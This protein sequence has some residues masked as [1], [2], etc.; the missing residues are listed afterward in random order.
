[1]D[2]SIKIL[3]DT[4]NIEIKRLGSIIF[5]DINHKESVQVPPGIYTINVY[6]EGVLI[7]SKSSQVSHDTV[8]S[9]VT[10]RGSFI[11]TVFVFSALILLVSACF[12]F[13]TKRVTFNVALKL[14]VL[15]LVFFSLVQLPD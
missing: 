2:Y 3:L 15:G 6:E 11:Q 8:I 13:L 14:F 1:M 7:G 9:I 12:L 4:L 10:S 5:D